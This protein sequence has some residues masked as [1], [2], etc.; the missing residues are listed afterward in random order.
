MLEHLFLSLRLGAGI[1]AVG[2][3]VG[4]KGRDLH[5]PRHPGFR[6]DA[7]DAA[8]AFALHGLESVAALIDQ[9]AHAVDDRIGIGHGRA[10]GKI[11]A[12]V[13]RHRLDLTD[14]A[15][16]AHEQ[17]LAGAA[18]GDADA[19]AKLCHAARDLA[20][21]EPRA[22]INRDDLRHQLASFSLGLPPLIARHAR[23]GKRDPL[24]RLPHPPSFRPE[25]PDFFAKP[26]DTPRHPV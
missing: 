25:P 21:D 2:I 4:T 16:G 23:P 8:C 22:A 14:R 5:Q 10:H 1:G 12:D 20:S 3:G 15:I 11:V 26:V 9:N 7:G 6:G 24:T 13:A 17:R 18:D 19:P